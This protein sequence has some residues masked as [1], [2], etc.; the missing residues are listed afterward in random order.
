MTIL[1]EAMSVV[2]RCDSLERLGSDG[3][4][5]V[6]SSIPNQT[7]CSDGSLARVGFLVEQD[8]LD[9]IS[10]LE[11]VGLVHLQGEESIDFTIVLQGQKDL[12]PCAWLERFELDYQGTLLDVAAF[13]DA[14][15][16]VHLGETPGDFVG[17]DGWSLDNAIVCH[18]SRDLT[19]LKS[20]PLEGGGIVE[21]Y[22]AQDGQIVYI[23]RQSRWFD[24]PFFIKPFDLC[25]VTSLL[26]AVVGIL[27]ISAGYGWIAGSFLGYLF[28]FVLCSI[29]VK[30]FP[31]VPQ[32]IGRIIGGKN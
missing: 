2:V 3:L 13:V 10:F 6:F 9:F 22:L 28:G 7:Y 11:S 23:G 8:A 25:R 15:G 20:Q 29:F 27:F 30:N 1:L 32:W 18:E 12:S 5:H 19:Y 4:D 14:N 16:N 24:L 17:P 31:K 26:G 21:H